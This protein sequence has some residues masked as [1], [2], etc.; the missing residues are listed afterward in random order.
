MTVRLLRPSEAD[1]ALALWN[2]SAPLDALSPAV[3]REKVWGEPAGTA[4]TADVDGTLVGLGV[5]VLWPTPD[6]LRGSVRLLAVEPEHRRRGIA[7]A[8]L[9]ALEDGL[10]QRGVTVARIG[11]ASP[12]YLT[13]GIDV[14]NDGGLAFAEARGY[15]EIGEAVN[16]GVDLT[17]DPRSG[18]GQ[19]LWRTDADEARL[20]ALGVG[21]HRATLADRPALG[22]LLDA[23]WPAWQAEA[24]R[25]LA[26]APPSLHLALRDGA[27]LGFAAFDANNVGT[28]WFGPMGTDP[29]ARGLGVGAVLLR[30]CLH[31]LR[32]Q[33]REHA[34]IAWAAALPFYERACGATVE[35]R[36]RRVEKAL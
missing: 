35:R 31:D 27:A 33:R 17:S 7:T 34:T 19:A 16:L 12:N 30:R 20:A 29:A 10:R 4:L 26:N 24:E 36:F 18:P 2:R 15:R 25:A 11:E 13:P 22:R 21:V 5:G 9:D 8:L 1:A 23:H 14:R 28:G 6:A 3:F 32:Q